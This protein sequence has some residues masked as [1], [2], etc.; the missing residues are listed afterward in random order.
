MIERNAA[1][2]LKYCSVAIYYYRVKARGTDSPHILE[3][4]VCMLS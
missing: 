1:E 3:K 4:S 2:I